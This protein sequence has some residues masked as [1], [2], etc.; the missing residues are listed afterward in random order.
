MTFTS[1]EYE[2]WKQSQAST[3]TANLASMSSTHAFLASRSLWVIDSRALAHMTGT[4]LTLSSLTPTTAYPP[5]SIEYGRSCSV[6]LTFFLLVPLPL[7][8][9]ALPFSTLSIVSSRTFMLVRELVWGMKM[10][11]GFMSSCRTP[12]PVGY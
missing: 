3:S 11:V 9:I 4:P 12:L 1:A 7:H 10:V 5:V 2:A 6:P 8:L